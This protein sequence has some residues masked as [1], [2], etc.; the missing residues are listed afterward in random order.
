[1]RAWA[2]AGGRWYSAFPWQHEEELRVPPARRFACC[3]RDGAQNCR[4]LS[5][6]RPRHV[7]DVAPS[8]ALAALR[9]TRS[10][11]ASEYGDFSLPSCATSTS[12]WRA[13]RD[14]R[15]EQQMRVGGGDRVSKPGPRGLRAPA[16]LS[17]RAA[18]ECC[19]RPTLDPTSDTG[20]A[21]Q[22]LVDGR[23][24]KGADVRAPA[25]LG[26]NRASRCLV[27]FG[28]RQLGL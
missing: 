4:S 18:G 25:R 7:F 23:T 19:R 13:D 8:G 20:R 22:A 3:A 26:S 27:L 17:P 21:W 24:T 10:I 9:G 1:M 11:A 15:G 14:R 6:L 2:R 28:S 16:V 12:C 5:R